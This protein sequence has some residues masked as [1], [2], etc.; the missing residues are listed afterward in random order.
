[1]IRLVTGFTAALL[2]LSCAAADAP[3]VRLHAAGSLRAAMT[4]IAKA[5]TGT[6]GISVQ[7]NFGA[8]GAMRD[9]LASGEPGDVFASAD[10]G[11]PQALMRTGK[12]GPVVLFARNHLCAIVRPGLAVTSENIL[13]KM[14]DPSIKVGTST[15]GS[16]PG[17]DYAWEVFRKADAQRPGSRA[18]LEA[19]A[20]KIG[21]AAGSMAVPP[22]ATNAVVWLF[23][24]KRVDIFLAYCT[25]GRSI[26]AELPGVATVALP[27]TLAV[28]ATY[29]LTLLTAGNRDRAAQFAFY[30]LSPAGQKILADHGFDAPLLPTTK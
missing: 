17:G 22:S 21:N 8:S 11:N 4:D 14:L 20:L 6:Y 30:I 23:N 7:T 10:M 26:A 18:T 9:R 3:S 29:G 16:D 27:P 19:K 25:G 15:P 5:Y 13:T 1:M 12:A 24:E 2:T 28:E